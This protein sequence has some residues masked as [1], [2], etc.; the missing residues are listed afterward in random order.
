[1][2]CRSMRSSIYVLLK[3]LNSLVERLKY[4]SELHREATEQIEKRTMGNNNGRPIRSTSANGKPEKNNNRFFAKTNKVFL[5]NM[6]KILQKKNQ[7][8]NKQL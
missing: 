1:M 5:I 4:D 7:P 6:G 3:L 2:A 8:F